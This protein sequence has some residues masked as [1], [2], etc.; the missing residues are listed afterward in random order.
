MALPA[1]GKSLSSVNVGFAGDKEASN[2][3]PSPVQVSPRTDHFSKL[4]ERSHDGNIDLD[5][6]LAMQ[7]AR[8]HRHPLFCKDVGAVF[9]ALPR[10]VFKVTNCDLKAVASF[11]V[12]WNMKSA[13]KRET[14]LLTA[15]LSVLAGTP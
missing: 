1:D 3:E 15:W 10:P 2:E 4:N 7:H 9:S 5:G 13:G 6:A 14:F 8:K 12:S 11:S